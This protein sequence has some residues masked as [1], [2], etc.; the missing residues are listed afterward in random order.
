M[1][2]TPQQK[3][4][5]KMEEVHMKKLMYHIGRIGK[6]KLFLFLAGCII[7]I[8]L[9]AIS[10]GGVVMFGRVIDIPTLLYMLLPQVLLLYVTGMGKP[11]VNGFKVA[12]AEK[13]GVSRMELQ[14]AV[15]AI[16]F[17]GTIAI[18]TAVINAMF[19]CVSILYQMADLSKLGPSL[20]VMFL[21]I[22]YAGILML[23][24]TPVQ[25]K[26]ESKEITYMEEPAEGET[27][28]DAGQVLFFKLRAFGLT[29]R[30]AEVARLVSRGLSN[31]E[32]GQLLYI[33]DTTV[34]KH[35]THILEKTGCSDRE[36][37]TTKVKE[38]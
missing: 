38:L 5:Q 4:K 20:A 2:E 1:E 9:I 17:S 33:S 15:K 8:I 13:G 3:E 36:E 25:M 16:R 18:I 12:F 23:F 34:K 14:L 27:E 7:I 6:S 35:V 29:D 37:L 22:L 30:E 11:F 10:C 26:L 32:I 19:G 31:K 28:T 24:L 21:S